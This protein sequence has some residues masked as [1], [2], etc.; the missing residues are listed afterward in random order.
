M[1]VSKEAIT[2]EEADKRWEAW[3]QAHTIN[4]AKKGPKAFREDKT[5]RMPHLSVGEQKET[6]RPQVP[7]QETPPPSS[8]SKKE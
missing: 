7:T 2:Q 8:A 5:Q 6:L 1:G 4:A 3:R